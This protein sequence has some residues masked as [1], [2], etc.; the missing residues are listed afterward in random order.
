MRYKL[1]RSNLF[2][3]ADIRSRMDASL[4]KWLEE[5]DVMYILHTHPAVFTVPEAEIHCGHI[6]GTH[7]K[8]LFVRNKKTNEYYLITIPAKKRLDLKA[9]RK[10]IGAPNVRFAD[11]KALMEILGLTPGAVSPLGLVND[12]IAEFFILI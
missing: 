7:I 9:F 1:K 11:D 2:Y 12:N 6:P 3:E 10:L 8:N 4:K 5:H